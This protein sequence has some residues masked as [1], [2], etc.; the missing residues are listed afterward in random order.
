MPEW[1]ITLISVAASTAVSTVVGLLLKHSFTK[2]FERKDREKEQVEADR[3]RLEK[4]E[5]QESEDKLIE[6]INQI[7]EKH[8]DPIDAQ[9]KVLADGTTDMLRERILSTYYKCIDKGYRTQYDFE[10]IEH[11]HKDYVLLGG[12]SFVAAC[13]ET[14]KK[15]P[16][17][18]E[19]KAA[20]KAAA[21]KRV[22]KTKK[23]I[24]NEKQ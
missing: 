11:M 18:E 7:V 4:F 15:L 3:K 22:R 17:E 14:I 21:P 19:F 24:L 10:N 9:L 12:N 20:Q 2:Y 13:V 23:K 8:T 16:S 5:K 6:S 1:L